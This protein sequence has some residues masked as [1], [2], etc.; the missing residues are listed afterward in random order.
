MKRKDTHL[1][2]QISQGVEPCNELV[3]CQRVNTELFNNLHERAAI[4]LANGN[5]IT[6]AA[7]EIGISHRTLQ[8]WLQDTYFCAV[9]EREKL[10]LREEL[11]GQIKQFGKKNWLP[12]AWYLERNR[13]FEGEFVQQRSGSGSGTNI[14]VNV[15]VGGQPGS[16]DGVQVKIGSEDVKSD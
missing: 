11:L 4:L 7:A 14:Q 5:T 6:S 9:V 10:K 8:Y 1:L 13:T 12:V 2:K 3:P 16:A 15:M